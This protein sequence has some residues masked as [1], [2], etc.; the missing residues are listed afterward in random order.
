LAPLSPST[1]DDDAAA[2]AFLE[3]IAMDSTCV[4]AYRGIALAHALMGTTR[5]AR[6]FA[7][8]ARRLGGF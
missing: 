5:H 7:S 1:R 8:S 6:A 3:A 2:E 4:E